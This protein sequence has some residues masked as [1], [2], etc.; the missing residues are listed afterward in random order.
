MI[1]KVVKMMGGVVIVYYNGNYLQCE[2]KGNVK[3]SDKVL[4]GDNVEL[5]KDEF[6][7]D[8]YIITKIMPRTNS[9]MRPPLANLDRLFIVVAPSPKPDFMLI[10]KLIIYC[11]TNNIKPALLVNKIDVTNDDFASIIKNQYSKVVEDILFV[12]GK[13]GEGVGQLKN[14]LKNNTSAFSGQSAVGKST[15][16]NSICPNLNLSTNVLSKKIERGQHTTR[17]N[18]IYVLE[19]GIYIADTPGFSMLELKGIDSSNLHNYYL[20]FAPFESD[21]TF[22]ECTH[23]NC[24]PK[25]CGV[26]KA[27]EGN[28]IDSNRYERYYKLY[29]QLKQNE[30]WK[31]D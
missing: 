28:L 31:Y 25:V 11:N 2:V 5:K 7:L 26:V 23:I 29:T 1:G 20:E 8:K 18:Q 15:L 3:K 6:S 12:S 27:V 14:M 30:E 10:D 13:T 24:P 17:H 16:I 21:C 22:R 4:V 9:L 19:E